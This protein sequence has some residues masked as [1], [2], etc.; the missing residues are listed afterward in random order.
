[1]P[2]DAA[3]GAR[4]C[5]SFG[6]E[7]LE[8]YASKSCRRMR[9]LGPDPDNCVRSTPASRALLRMAGEGRTRPCRSAGAGPCPAPVPFERP[10]RAPGGEMFRAA[11]AVPSGDAALPAPGDAAPAAPND[12]APVV[13]SDAEDAAGCAAALGDLGAASAVS[14]ATAG[15]VA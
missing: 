2:P 13:P 9:P 11:R 8:T 14:A 5:T 1:S 6:P 4:E 12:A 15:A 7:R 3:S 10:E